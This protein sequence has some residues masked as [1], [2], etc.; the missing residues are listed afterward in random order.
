[1][2]SMVSASPW[3]LNVKEVKFELTLAVKPIPEMSKSASLYGKLDGPEIVLAN[4]MPVVIMDSDKMRTASLP[5]RRLVFN[6][7]PHVLK[8]PAGHK[9]WGII[10]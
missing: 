6:C 10:S 7:T 9:H 5:V 8:C 3:L 1:M 4:M 2:R